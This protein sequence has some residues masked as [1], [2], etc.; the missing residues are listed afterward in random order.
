MGVVRLA[1]LSDGTIIENPRALQKGQRKIKRFQKELGRKEK[2]KDKANRAKSRMKLARAYARVRNVRQDA[3]HKA[4]TTLTKSHGRIVIEDL[5]VANMTRSG[6]SRKRGLNRVLLDA[7]LGEFRRMLEY[8]G[9]LYG[10]EVVAVPPHY[11]SQRCSACGYVDAGNRRSQSEFRCL[12]CGIEIN[13]DLNASINILVAGS[14][15][16]TQNAC[17]ADVRRRSPFGANLQSAVK[18]ESAWV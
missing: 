11:T 10:C 7:S 16:E 3:L 13:A 9:K 12:L 17:G 18:Q 6:G 15:P 5:K 14:C 4:S 8:K 2:G 1:T